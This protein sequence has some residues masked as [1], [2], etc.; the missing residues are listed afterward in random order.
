MSACLCYKCAVTVQADQLLRSQLPAGRRSDLATYLDQV[1]EVTV[2][3][4][5]DRYGVSIDTVRRDLDHLHN[6]GR[7]VRTHGGAVSVAVQNRA[8]HGL[9]VRLHMQAEQKEAIGALAAELVTDGSVLIVNAG[10]TTLAVARALHM[11]RNLIIATNNLLLPGAI[12]EKTF[13]EM[14]VFGG[15]MRILTQ[16]TTGPVRFPTADGHDM[17]IS[18]DLAFVAVGAV[19]AEG[20]YTTSNLSEAIMMREM[21][22]QSA[23]VA[24]LADSSKFDRRLFATVADLGLADYFITDRE[25]PPE[26]RQA[27]GDAGVTVL[28]PRPDPPG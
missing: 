18:A 1:G 4:L 26:L 11:R 7:V 8:D 28:F 6:G 5:A 13:R 27:L 15:A 19:S 2:H 21:M 9:S 22:Q 20:G 10:T 23:K 16:S 24:V 3:E 17:S 14:Y 25:P 12:S